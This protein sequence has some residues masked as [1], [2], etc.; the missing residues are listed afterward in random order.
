[1][2]LFVCLCLCLTLRLFICCRWFIACQRHIDAGQLRQHSAR[3]L[4]FLPAHDSFLLNLVLLCQS[5]SFS[6]HPHALYSARLP[7][8]HLLHSLPSSIYT[9]MCPNHLSLLSV[10]IIS[11]FCRAVSADFQE[12]FQEM[13]YQ[14]RTCVMCRLCYNVKI[15]RRIFKA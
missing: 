2:Y 9:C 13:Q 14:P 8:R 7:L 5:G 1:M 6:A 4:C 10:I 3:L 11:N 12:C 15:K